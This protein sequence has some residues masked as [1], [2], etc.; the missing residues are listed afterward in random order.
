MAMGTHTSNIF[1]KLDDIIENYSQKPET[2]HPALLHFLHD[3][4]FLLFT[5]LSFFIL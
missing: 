1:G 5:L 3:S 4:E 2:M